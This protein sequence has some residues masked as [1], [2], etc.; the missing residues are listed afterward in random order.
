[1]RG[2]SLRSISASVK[3]SAALVT[4]TCY[5]K[6]N[7]NCDVF[8]IWFSFA[9]SLCFL[10]LG[11]L[12]YLH[13]ATAEDLSQMTGAEGGRERGW[14]GVFLWWSY[15][16]T[17][18]HIISK[19]SVN[20]WPLVSRDGATHTQQ[21]RDAQQGPVLHCC[22]HHHH[23]RHRRRRSLLEHWDIILPLWRKASVELLSKQSHFAAGIEIHPQ[24]TLPLRTSENTG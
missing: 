9:F 6:R 12:L 18:F 11:L 5:G 22:H 1:M 19:I 20:H 17:V 24:P 23:H 7:V 2:G 15:H 8:A 10:V 21:G 14:V 4:V 13:E 3:C 16:W